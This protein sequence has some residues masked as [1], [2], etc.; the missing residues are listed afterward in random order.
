MTIRMNRVIGN[1]VVDEE[2]IRHN[3]ELTGG[4]VFSGTL[5]LELA[6]RGVLRETAY[7]WVQRNAMKVWDEGADF[8]D[9]ILRDPDI[10]AHLAP[11]E[12]EM[13]FSLEEKLKYIDVVFRRV[14]GSS[15][16]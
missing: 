7:V 15:K 2:R 3:I 16:Y 6:R 10:T 1:L 8:K 13:A 11:E 5:L 4:L 9:L 12:I 14:F